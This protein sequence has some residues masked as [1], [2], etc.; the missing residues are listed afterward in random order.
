MASPAVACSR[1]RRLADGIFGTTTVN[2]Y[3]DKTYKTVIE[4]RK[5]DRDHDGDRY[6]NDDNDG[7][8]R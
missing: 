6:H 5:R 4:R 7:P 3:V 2:R 8:G 1:A